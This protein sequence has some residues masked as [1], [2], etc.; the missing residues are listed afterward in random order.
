MTVRK[1]RH[2]QSTCEDMRFGVQQSRENLTPS[3]TPD[4][5]TLLTAPT[6]LTFS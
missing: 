3:L 1:N 2:V 6:H 5:S 4:G